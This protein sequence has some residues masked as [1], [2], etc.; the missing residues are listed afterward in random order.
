MAEAKSDK[1]HNLQYSE[2]VEKVGPLGYAKGK[3]VQRNY[4]GL[5]D[6]AKKEMQQNQ[7]SYQEQRLYAILGNDSLSN[8]FLNLGG[9]FK[10][11][12]LSAKMIDIAKTNPT[13]YAELQ[14]LA[15]DIINSYER[16]KN[17]VSKK[18]YELSRNIR[19]NNWSNG[20][21]E[22]VPQKVAVQNNNSAKQM[23]NTNSLSGKQ[24]HSNMLQLWQ[25]MEHES[26]LYESIPDIPYNQNAID[27]SYQRYSNY[28]NTYNKYVDLVE[29]IIKSDPVKAYEFLIAYRA[30]PLE[31]LSND[32]Y[33][34]LDNLIQQYSYKVQNVQQ[35]QDYFNTKKADSDYNF[36]NKEKE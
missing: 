3:P 20:Y 9:V 34:A 15:Q 35:T 14:R 11:S 17:S 5:S 22:Q 2:N 4:T 12:E 23:V 32:E 36:M 8:G 16:D 25:Y 24:I 19:M 10:P 31:P 1:V 28:I 30:K 27:A 33:T 21:A 6:A 18:A 13:E 7:A 29:S 26:K